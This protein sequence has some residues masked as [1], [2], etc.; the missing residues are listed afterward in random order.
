MTSQRGHGCQGEVARGQTKRVRDAQRRDCHT[1]MTIIVVLIAAQ[2]CTHD[3]K[4][5]EQTGKGCKMVFQMWVASGH[6]QGWKVGFWLA[7]ANQVSHLIKSPIGSGNRHGP[8]YCNRI[9]EFKTF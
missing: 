5:Q 4:A 2:E 9:V 7:N 6:G 3:D 8:E 1:S